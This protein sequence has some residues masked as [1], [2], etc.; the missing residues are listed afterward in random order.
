MKKRIVF[1]LFLSTLFGPPI[2]AMSE[3]NIVVYNKDGSR[4]AYLLEEKPKL[5]FTTTEL[6]ISIKAMEIH[7]SMKDIDKLSYEVVN[8]AG[9]VTI[10]A[11]NKIEYAD[12]AI[13]YSSKKNEQLAIYDAK[14]VLVR[15]TKVLAGENGHMSL[16][17]LSAGLYVI[18]IG[19]TSYK[20]YKK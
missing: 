9:I 4:V 1:L 19:N 10:K 14:G 11:E 6:L 15:K 8:T 3:M 16:S 5:V 2:K 12:G 17:G 13:L 20:V 18:T 7:Y